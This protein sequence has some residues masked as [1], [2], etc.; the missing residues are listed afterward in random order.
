MYS[1][2]FDIYFIWNIQAF[3]SVSSCIAIWCEYELIFKHLS[4]DVF[5]FFSKTEKKS[6]DVFKIFRICRIRCQHFVVDKLKKIS[7]AETMVQIRIKKLFTT[8]I[9]WCGWW[10]RLMTICIIRYLLYSRY[11]MEQMFQTMWWWYSIKNMLLFS[12][13]PLRQASL[14]CETNQTL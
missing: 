13:H 6:A 14:S 10:L 8:I 11:S 5:A 3:S 1:F 2:D 7:K 9:K 4:L 12:C